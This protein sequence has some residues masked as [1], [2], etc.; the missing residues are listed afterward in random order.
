MINSKQFR[1]EFGNFIKNERKKQN[2]F[3]RD[4]CSEL[5]ITQAYYS[6]IENG[7]REV[8]IVLAKKICDVL[9]VGFDTFIAHFQELVNQNH[10]DCNYVGSLSAPPPVKA[11]LDQI[12]KNVSNK[13]ENP[14]CEI[15]QKGDAVIADAESPLVNSHILLK[16]LE[17]RKKAGKT[18][19]MYLSNEASEKLDRI[20]NQYKCSKG[21]VV[22]ALLE[23][24][25]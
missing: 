1:E 17:P 18:C 12:A 19:S 6:T 20:A 21:K 24:I 25:P 14:D 22:E 2:L 7:K 4:I 3:Q 23:N 9:N 11:K 5:G 10:I 15:I 16:G 8:G 13:N